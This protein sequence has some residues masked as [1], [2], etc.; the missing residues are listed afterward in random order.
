MSINL[1]LKYTLLK[2]P[3]VIQITFAVMVDMVC[4]WVEVY[5]DI[6]ASGHRGSL[7]MATVIQVEKIFVV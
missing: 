5:G 1:S 4:S 6:S 7:V 3:N 2:I